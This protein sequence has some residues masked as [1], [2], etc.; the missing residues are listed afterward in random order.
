MGPSGIIKR[1]VKCHKLK[2]LF[3]D[4]QEIEKKSR[5]GGQKNKKTHEPQAEII[6]VMT[7]TDFFGARLDPENRADSSC[8]PAIV[9]EN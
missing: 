8:A 4:L 1:S 5:V 2:S 3:L 9:I 6:I 7:S